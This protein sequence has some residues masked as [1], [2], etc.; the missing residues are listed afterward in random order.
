[1]SGGAIIVAVCM[2]ILGQTVFAG[3][4]Q[5]FDYIYYWGACFIVTL[6]A[7]VAA[8]FEM[9]AIRKQSRREQNRLVEET[10][11]ENS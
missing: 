1:M 2:V 7:A 3:R 6:L 10:F 8:L 5:G 9:A 4:L 11:G